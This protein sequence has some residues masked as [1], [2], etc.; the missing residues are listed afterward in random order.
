MSTGPLSAHPPRALYYR[1]QTLAAGTRNDG[2]QN[3]RGM[4]ARADTNS[5]RGLAWC[6]GERHCNVS[7]AAPAPSEAAGAAAAAA[8]VIPPKLHWAPVGSDRG[9]DSAKVTIVPPAD[10]PAEGHAESAAGARA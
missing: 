2:G 9:S 8:E 10:G 5:G 7:T 3:G 4:H 6:D 1:C